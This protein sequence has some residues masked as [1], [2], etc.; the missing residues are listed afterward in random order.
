MP[1]G[2]R[3]EFHWQPD[4][5]S[6]PQQAFHFT[7]FTLLIQLKY[8]LKDQISHPFI[9]LIIIITKHNILPILASLLESHI[10]T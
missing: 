5:S 3:F 2:H 1:Q 4:S 9:V 8:Y 6:R 7:A 10:V